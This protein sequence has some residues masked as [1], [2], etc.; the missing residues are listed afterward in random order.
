MRFRIPALVDAVR[1]QTSVDRSAPNMSPPPFDADAADL[2]IGSSADAARRRREELVAEFESRRRLRATHAPTEDGAVRKA[3]RRRGEPVTLFG[4]GPGDRRE[5]LR[6]ILAA[7]DAVD[8]GE[9]D[10]ANAN[11]DDDADD[12]AAARG[13][14]EETMKQQ[15]EVFYTEGTQK[16]LEARVELA[17]WSLPRAAKRLATQRATRADAKRD[18]RMEM[19]AVVA[20]TSKFQA[21]CSEIG[22]ATRPLCGVR[23]YDGGQRAVSASWSGEAKRWRCDAG[24][25]ALTCDLTIRA[26]DHRITGVDAIKTVGDDLIATAHADGTAA[27]WSAADGSRRVEF[28]GHA[29]RCGK[30]AFHPNDG[31]YIATAGFD[32][33]WRLWNVATGDE[34][35]CQE[36][37]A[38][39][40]YDVAFHPDGSLAASVGLDAVGRV[41]DLRTGRSIAILR[42]HVKQILSVDFSP[43]GYHLVTGSDDRTVRCWDLR[44]SA[45]CAYT[46]AAHSGLV[47]CVKYEKTTSNGAFF[48]S[49]SYDGTVNVYSGRDF[50][51]N[52]RLGGSSGGTGVVNKLTGVDVAGDALVV[53]GFDKTLKLYTK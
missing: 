25:G 3:L 44:K 42:G 35:L 53:S 2:D 28:R 37:H 12:D 27:V 36:G 26:T 41:W 48:A 15:K 1:E 50:A 23:F 32:A 52:T 47:S 46:S 7:L 5:R 30:V 49:C 11:A 51:L 31:K 45:E 38:K 34:L 6:G 18:E 17:E 13:H 39:E 24:S 43:N 20:T 22:D 21:Q 4:E 10:D 8:G 19:D 29:S 33:T 14:H 16:L 40:V 9:L